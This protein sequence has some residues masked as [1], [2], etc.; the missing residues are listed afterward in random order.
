VDI[1]DTAGTLIGLSQLPSFKRQNTEPLRA[2]QVFAADALATSLGAFLGT[3][4][5]T[6]YVESAA[7]MEEGGKT[8]L[9]AVVVGGMFLLRVFFWPVAQAVPVAAT[10]PALIIVGFLMMGN[11]AFI[12]WPHLLEAFPAFI[13]VVMIPFTFSIADGISAGVFAH[14]ALNLGAG[15]FRNISPFLYCLGSVLL[16]RFF[17]AHLS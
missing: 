5:A 14:I 11:L 2:T 10:A 13:T 4:T 3:S 6:T 16:L 9:T 17:Y 7:G 1:F 8:G 12:P 15:R